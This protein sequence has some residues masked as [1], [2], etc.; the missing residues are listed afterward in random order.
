MYRD[1]VVHTDRFQGIDHEAGDMS[2][3]ATNDLGIC[4]E[5]CATTTRCVDVSLSGDACYLKSSLGAALSDSL[6]VG[7]RLVDISCSGSN[8]TIYSYPSGATFKIECG[9][10]H[11]GGDMG[12]ATV[13]SL[14]ACIQACATTPGCV[15]TLF[16]RQDHL[17]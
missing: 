2:W 3:F 13:S 9:V 11:V 10:D 6:I 14:A 7:A 15:R 8:N 1:L 16:P 17:S 4:I 5:S 12:S